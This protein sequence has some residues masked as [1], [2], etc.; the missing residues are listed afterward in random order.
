MHHLIHEES[1]MFHKIPQ[2]DLCLVGKDCNL[3]MDFS[4]FF[5]L[6]MNTNLKLNNFY[7]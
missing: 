2:T 1:Q 6:C 4:T 7:D 3:Y 5:L